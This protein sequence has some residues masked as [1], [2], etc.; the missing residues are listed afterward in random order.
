MPPPGR[1]ASRTKR[2]RLRR[3]SIPACGWK[4]ECLHCVYLRFAFAGPARTRKISRLEIP[5]DLSQTIR[6]EYVRYFRH[7]AVRVEKALRA[8]PKDKVYV[9]P[10]AFGNSLGHLVLHLTGNLN[11]Y[12]GA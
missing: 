1:S 5:M 10:F 11:H 8:V 9:K 4:Y 2:I 12:I 7:L 3:F 6:D